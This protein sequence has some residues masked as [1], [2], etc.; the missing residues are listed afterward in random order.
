MKLLRVSVFDPHPVIHKALTCTL[1]GNGFAVVS[2]SFDGRNAVETVR[3]SKAEIVITEIRMPKV[4]GLKMLASLQDIDVRTIVYTS[5][6]NPTYLARAAAIGTDDYVLKTD[7]FDCLLNAMRK[8]AGKNESVGQLSNGHSSANIHSNGNSHFNGEATTRSGATTTQ[9]TQRNRLFQEIS[10]RLQS[11]DVSPN[12][13]QNLTSREAQVLRHL[14]FGLS[15]REIAK[16]LQIS[17][18]TVKEHVQNILR[19]LDCKDRTAA[20]V[21]AVREGIS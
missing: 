11:K 13:P 19:K 21:W 17:V 20:A 2:Q 8:V 6:T 18:E 3:E 5:D 12:N 10:D 1:P 9:P 14:G 16:S 4:D 7:P 15:N